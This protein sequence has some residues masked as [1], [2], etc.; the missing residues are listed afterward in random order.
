MRGYASLRYAVFGQLRPIE[1]N[2]EREHVAAAGLVSIPTA[3]A[4]VPI[5]VQL[6]AEPG[7]QRNQPSGI[8]RHR[9]V[10]RAGLDD[11]GASRAVPR[12][13]CQVWWAVESVGLP[14]EKAS[15]YEF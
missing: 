13:A 12:W 2:C 9:S 1:V 5:A 15:I 10:E 11:R 14:G 7:L 8:T 3:G 4:E 6:D